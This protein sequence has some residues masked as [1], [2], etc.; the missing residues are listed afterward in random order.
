MNRFDIAL[1]YWV[2][3]TLWH[4]GGL[5]ERCREKGRGIAA[6]L[7]A[8]RFRPGND[9][10]SAEENEGAREVYLALIERYHG[11]GRAREEEA[12]LLATEET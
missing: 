10:L 9:D 1:G 2:F 4:S 11:A 6:Q 12:E 5:T 8:L 3:Y 7:H